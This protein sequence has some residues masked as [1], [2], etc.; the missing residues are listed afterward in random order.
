MESQVK[1]I[2]LE[3]QITI[4]RWMNQSQNATSLRMKFI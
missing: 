2:S 3:E 4:S 1:R